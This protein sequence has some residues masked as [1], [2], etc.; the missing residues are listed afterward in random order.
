MI[1]LFESPRALANMPVGRHSHLISPNVVQKSLTTVRHRPGVTASIWQLPRAANLKAV[2]HPPAL[3][4][5]HDVAFRCSLHLST[6][7][8]HAGELWSGLHLGLQPRIL[9]CRAHSCL[10]DGSKYW[11]QRSRQHEG[12]L[13]GNLSNAGVISGSCLGR[14]TTQSG[15]V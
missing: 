13:P 6:T 14:G 9:V 1:R 4:E 11:F 3:V 12:G 7:V 2:M 15:D 10:Y 8:V 5:S